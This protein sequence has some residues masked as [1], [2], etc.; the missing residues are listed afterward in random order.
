M[1]HILL[2][3]ISQPK[4]DKTKVEQEISTRTKKKKKKK[5]KKNANDRRDTNRR[6][7]AA[8]A[9]ARRHRRRSMTARHRQSAPSR[10][11]CRCQ[12]CRCCWCCCCDDRALD[13][14]EV[15]ERVCCCCQTNHTKNVVPVRPDGESALSASLLSVALGVAA[16]AMPLPRWPLCCDCCCCCCC[17]RWLSSRVYALTLFAFV[18]AD[19]RLSFDDGRSEDCDRT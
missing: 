15:I 19:P 8:V 3:C 9:A 11:A 2:C 5:K 7:A 4:A 13:R 10:T 12:R 6:R 14:R 16:T 18:V 1:T 17:S